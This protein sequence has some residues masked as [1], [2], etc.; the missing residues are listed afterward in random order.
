MKKI[1]VGERIDFLNDEPY[2]DNLQQ[3]SIDAS[4]LLKTFLRS[5]GEPVTTN[6]LYPKLAALSG[7]FV[8][9]QSLNLLKYKLFL[10]HTKEF[11]LR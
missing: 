2:R 11:I 8:F 9:P 6:A 4:V 5:L 1:F 7:G 3:A 10:S